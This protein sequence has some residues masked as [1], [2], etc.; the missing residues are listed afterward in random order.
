MSISL[1]HR[2]NFIG[3]VIEEQLKR[4]GEGSVGE[5]D[6]SRNTPSSYPEEAREDPSASLGIKD[7]ESVVIEDFYLS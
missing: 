7:N 2:S 6:N 3:D 1:Y 5:T 4:N